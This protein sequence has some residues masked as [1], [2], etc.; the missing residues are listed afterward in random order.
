MQYTTPGERFEVDIFYNDRN[1]LEMPA[2]F[3]VSSL[4]LKFN[5]N[6]YFMTEKLF[7]H[8]KVFELYL[9]NVGKS[10]IGEVIPNVEP[11]VCA[12]LLWL[13]PLA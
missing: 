6:I 11:L 8:F 2:T 3:P 13:P 1:T 5:A 10:M 9:A 4:G 12:R 7:G